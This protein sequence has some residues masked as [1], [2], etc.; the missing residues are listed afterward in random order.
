MMWNNVCPFLNSG[1]F[2]A[3]GWIGM[4]LNLLLSVGLIAGLVYLVVWLVRRVGAQA[5][6]SGSIANPLTAREIAQVRYAQGEINREE[7]LK[8]IE[9]LR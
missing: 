6:V 5:P 9:D 7:Y 4:I 3:W 2:G 8:L 1:T